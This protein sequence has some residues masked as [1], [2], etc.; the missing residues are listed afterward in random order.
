M[1]PID[2]PAT[3][4]DH[5]RVTPSTASRA[6]RVRVLDADADL[7]EGLDDHQLESARAALVTPAID[8]AKGDWNPCQAVPPSRGHLGVLVLEGILS[9]EV[10]IDSSLCA[11]LVGPGDLL[12]PWEGPGAGGLVSYDIH[13]HVLEDAR[14]AVL[15]RRFVT[16]AARWP[17]LTSALVARAITRSNAL[18][19]AAAI[20]GTIGLDARLL[21]LFWHMADRWGKVRPDG[22]VVPVRLTHELIARLIG[23]RRPSVSTA[24][25]QL[26]REGQVTRVHSGGWLLPGD[27][28]RTAIVGR[29]EVGG[30]VDPPAQ[31][32]R[33]SAG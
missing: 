4:R 32:L 2:R 16:L 10:A 12:R 31:G 33:R 13:W 22:V 27:P 9:R 19:L 29:D 15:D 25:K 8:L 21:M 7:G 14:L 6:A 3:A 23:A 11:E 18:A 24:L 17:S 5:C 20:P 28:P 26:E 30:R 1:T